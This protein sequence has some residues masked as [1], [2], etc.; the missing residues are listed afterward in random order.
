MSCLQD[1]RDTG[2]GWRVLAGP[3]PSSRSVHAG[4]TLWAVINP[5]IYDITSFALARSRFSLMTAPM[6]DD[7]GWRDKTFQHCSMVA[8]MSCAIS[9]AT[10]TAYLGAWCMLLGVWHRICIVYRIITF[11]ALRLPNAM[12]F[13]CQPNKRMN[14]CTSLYWVLQIKLS[15]KLFTM[16]ARWSLALMRYFLCMWLLCCLAGL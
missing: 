8:D 1:G 14:Y 6:G 3:R 12:I 16:G 2:G 9:R 11:P 15:M 4:S 13:S 5:W 10:H 7:A